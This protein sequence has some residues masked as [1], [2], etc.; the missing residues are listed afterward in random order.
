[1]FEACMLFA[2]LCA[3]LCQL[4]PPAPPRRSSLPRPAEPRR[5]RPR[6]QASPQEVGVGLLRPS[7]LVEDS[8]RWPA[9]SNEKILC[10]ERLLC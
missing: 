1:M 6:G 7:P 10:K 9:N 3:G 5:P 8:A 4:L 2:F